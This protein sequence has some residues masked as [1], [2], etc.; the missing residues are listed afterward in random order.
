MELAKAP[1]LLRHHLQYDDVISKWLA[2]VPAEDR[3][4]YLF[5]IAA[6]WANEV[7]DTR[8]YHHPTWHYVNFPVVRRG[9]RRVLMYPNGQVGIC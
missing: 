3:D 6:R 9:R 8:I 4:R 1:D 7:R 5:M 2:A